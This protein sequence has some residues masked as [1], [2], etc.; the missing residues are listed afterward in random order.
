MAMLANFQGNRGVL[1]VLALAVRSLW[2]RKQPGL[3]LHTC[4]LNLHDAR[5]V[6]EL[7]SRTGGA[8]LLPILNT[9]I[10]GVDTS[11]LEGGTSRA[12]LA[13]RANPHPHPQGFPFH[14]Y[15]WKD[16]AL[17]SAAEAA[18]RGWVEVVKPNL[19][20]KGKDTAEQL[21]RLLNRIGGLYSRGASSTVDL[22]DLIGLSLPNGGQLRIRL[23]ACPP[24]DMK[25]L[26]ELFEV[27]AGLVSTT[28]AS[29]A[30]IQ[31]KDLNEDCPFVKALQP[32][33][34]TPD[35]Q[36]SGTEQ[37]PSSQQRRRGPPRPRRR[38]RKHTGNGPGDWH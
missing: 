3:M 1:R 9:D 15:A 26:A 25:Q 5:I 21:V 36:T 14:E 12:M 31:I 29:N 13:D 18:R 27:L 6:N 23:Q 16:D 7:I 28:P 11:M 10:G 2:E 38:C 17:V 32:K 24:E 22:L 4:H 19:E 30:Q 8:E 33:N 37:H 35:K 20:R 34:P